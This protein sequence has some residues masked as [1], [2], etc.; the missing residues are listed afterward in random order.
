MTTASSGAA[1]AAR[2]SSGLIELS[3]ERNIDDRIP[4][5]DLATLAAIRSRAALS[6]SAVYQR[7]R[8]AIERISF[9]LAYGRPTAPAAR[10]Q[11]SFL[12]VGAWNIERGR[13]L[14][15]IRA[16]LQATPLLRDADLLLLNEVDVGMA[17]SGNRDVAA[18]LAAALGFE[19]VF[20]N[21]YLCLSRGN[22]RDGAPEEDNHIGLHGNAI[23]SRFPIRRAEN[24]SVTIS[25]DKFESSEKRLGHKKALWAEIDTPLGSLPVCTLHLDSGASPA[26]RAAQLADVLALLDARIFA[27]ESGERPPRCL[28]GGDFNTTTYDNKSVPRL[29][30]N[31]FR[32]LTRGGFAHAMHHYLHPDKLYEKSIFDALVESGFDYHGFNHLG[33][34]TIRYEVGSFESESKVREYLPGVALSILRWRLRPWDGVASLKLDWF[35][36]RGLHALTHEQTREPAPERVSQDPTTIERPRWDDALLSDH[37]PIVVDIAW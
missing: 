33:R 31:T 6:R 29:L 27:S 15:G 11:R 19:Y 7:H 20:G 3:A 23:L 2:T 35:A 8:A 1:S 22:Q 26:Q 21:S 4:A 14:P 5:P 12:R 17:R 28:I 16:Y 13:R 24:F 36:G 32:K 30:W 10:P 18:E 34:G 37:D 9:G 25:K